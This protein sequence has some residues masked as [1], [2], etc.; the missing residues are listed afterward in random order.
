MSKKN[1]KVRFYEINDDE[2]T[3]WEAYGKF[4]ESDVHHQ[5]AIVC[6]TPAYKNKDIDKPVE[7]FIELIRPSDDERSYPP[8][9]FR[10]KPRDAI[11]SRK[12]RRTCSTATTSSG[13]SNSMSS[14]ELP[15]I[16]QEQANVMQPPTAAMTTE[17]Q[18]QQQ[19]LQHQLMMQQQQEQ[20][21]GPP[22]I[23]EEFNKDQQLRNLYNSEEFRQMINTNSEELRIICDSFP[24]EGY[25]EHDGTSSSSSSSFT[26]EKNHGPQNKKLTQ[27]KQ[28]ISTSSAPLQTNNLHLQRI[29]KLYQESRNEAPNTSRYEA[30]AKQV[31]EIF[32]EF[33]T[34]HEEFDSIIHEIIIT[35]NVKLG[36]KTCDILK[37]FNLEGLLNTSINSNGESCLHCACLHNKAHFIRPLLLLGC[38][39]NIQ[40]HNGNTALHIAVQERNKN[41][42]DSFL[43]YMSS[44]PKSRVN[45]KL[46][47]DAGLTPLHLAIRNNM[48]DNI[49]K[50]LRYDKSAV[51]V[52]NTKDGNNALHMAVVHQNVPLIKLIMELHNVNLETRNAAGRTVLD[53]TKMLDPAARK[54]ILELLLQTNTEDG[55]Q[56]PT[57]KV[58]DTES[59]SSTE[60]DEEVEE[61]EQMEEPLELVKI[62]FEVDE[63]N[64]EEASV[65]LDLDAKL[66]KIL[67][68]EKKFRQLSQKLDKDKGW[69][70]LAKQLK[71]QHLLCLWSSADAMLK[72]VRDNVQS[73][74]NAAFIEALELVDKDTLILFQSM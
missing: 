65:G 17:Y 63:S 4:R 22:T 56:Q 69:K 29:F 43:I 47:N 67:C 45:L 74:G 42:I 12:R 60:D 72:Y 27:S 66:H 46:T 25:L 13:S 38:D 40:D 41:C 59:S 62:K 32:L 3:V 55:S 39:P 28:Y 30:V 6:T 8:V 50:F 68:D 64:I 51:L 58:E 2:E 5:Y 48:L 49:E 1:I 20:H 15:K 24:L 44:S 19:Q 33:A 26:V 57:V 18:Q 52:C 10:Y 16:L 53:L 35:D 23:S 9:T 61:D 11:V 34:K 70:P 71:M 7:V 36:I 54:N 14:F 21:V 37:F 31:S 73:I